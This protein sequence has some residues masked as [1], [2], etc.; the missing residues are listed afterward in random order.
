MTSQHL[1]L[2]LVQP[3]SRS[4][5]LAHTSKKLINLYVL[6]IT[7]QP[8]MLENQSMALK[9]VPVTSSKNLLSPTH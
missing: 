5:Q 4:K 7:S 6:A 1:P 3:S 9:M 2:E 8:L